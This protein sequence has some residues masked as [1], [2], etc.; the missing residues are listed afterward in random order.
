VASYAHLLAGFTDSRLLG[1][2]RRTSVARRVFGLAEVE[3]VLGLI[4]D[5]LE[6]W[7]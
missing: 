1:K 6:G 2:F 7:G 5:V 3:S 4:M